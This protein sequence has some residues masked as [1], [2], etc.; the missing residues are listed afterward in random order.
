MSRPTTIVVVDDSPD[1]RTLLRTQ[2]RLSGEL[3]V[4]AEGANGLEAVALATRHQPDLMLLDVSMPVVDGLTALP[5]VRAASPTTQVVMY[6]GFDEKGLAARAADLGAAAFVEKSAPFE[7]LI[8]TLV[9]LASLAGEHAPA[10]E[11]DVPEGEP[12]VLDPVLEE[13][14]ERF[15][16]EFEDAS[17]GMATMTL[18]GRLVRANRRLA[19]LLETSVDDLAGVALADLAE[20]PAAINDALLSLDAGEPAVE[21][22]HRLRSHEGRVLRSTL[23]PVIDVRGRPL[24]VF[25]RVQDV[26]NELAAERELRRTEARFKLLVEA[27]EDYAIFMLDPEGNISSWNAGAERSKGYT[28]EE[29]IGKHFRIFYP[30]E[31]QESRHPEH[32]LAEALRVGRYEEE[33][34]RIRKDGTRFWAN[35]TITAVRDPDG[36]LVGFA[37]V[38]RDTTERR[39]MLER[40]EE[41][42]RRLEEANQQLAALAQQQEQFFAVTA[43]E[44]R[45]PVSVLTGATSTL[46]GSF[47]VLEPQDR[48]DIARAVSNSSAQLRRLLEDLLTASRLQA[49]RLALDPIELDLNDQLESI[50]AGVRQSTRS[51]QIRFT[52]GPPVRVRADPVRLT[53]MFDNLLMN[54]IRHGEPPVDLSLTTDAHVAEIVV[55]DSGPGV[56]EE[57]HGR[58]FERFETGSSSGTGLGLFLVRELARAH[59]GEATYRQ[60]DRAF[61]VTLPTIVEP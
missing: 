42:N 33:G 26:S 22:E 61:V 24:Y 46:T 35:V 10:S 28:A 21:V 4:V 12:P 7:V 44:L 59:G 14:L 30:T 52:K 57:L 41:T 49:R 34:W 47:D 51:A 36:E 16:E 55:R 45:A 2:V 48:T 32:E 23:S 6:T 13:H 40:L 18:A 38:T 9:E 53:Q 5:R 39:N 56:P 1:V 31:K 27:V 54:A 43:H 37:K 29:I 15:H 60:S 11:T 20:E 8:G 3:E 25:V 50:T 19:Q 58:L 17:V